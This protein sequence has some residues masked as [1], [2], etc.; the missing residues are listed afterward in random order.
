MGWAAT[1]LWLPRFGDLYGR[2]H[3]FTAGATLDFILYSFLMVTESLNTTV[4]LSGLFGMLASVRVSVGFIYLM[5]L[6]P[7]SSRTTVGSV[8]NICGGCIYPLATLYFWFVSKNW[9]YFVANGYFLCLFS[10]CSAL[11]LPESPYFL[12]EL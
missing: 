3:I 5:E 7:K 2:K 4:V 11:L 12:I 1:L 8:S 10:A 9:L 6:M